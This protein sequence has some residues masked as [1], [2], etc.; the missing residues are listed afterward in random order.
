M[1]FAAIDA[2]IGYAIPFEQWRVYPVTGPEAEALKSLEIEDVYRIAAKGIARVLHRVRFQIRPRQTELQPM[3]L[4]SLRSIEAI[5]ADG[6]TDNA[7]LE[8]LL[9]EEKAAR[10]LENREKLKLRTKQ[11]GNEKDGTDSN[12]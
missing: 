6:E 2:L 4:I 3:F 1:E 5:L 10:Y 11:R 8:P 12:G 9:G 7:I